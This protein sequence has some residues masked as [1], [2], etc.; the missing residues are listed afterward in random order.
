M[1]KKKLLLTSFIIIT[2]LIICLLIFN[3]YNGKMIIKN[4]SNVKISKVVDNEYIGYVY[5]PKIKLKKN[6]FTFDSPKNN[7]E[8]NVKVLKETIFPQNNKNNSIVFLAAHSGTGDNAYFND[9]K[10]LNINDEIIINYKDTIYKYIIIDKKEV[11]KNGYITGNR[12]NNDEIVL[13]TCS[14]NPKKQLIINGILQKN[15]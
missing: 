11:E 7:I 12:I 2:Y 6:I 8:Y 15:N 3:F 10:L 4:N 13:T 5:I 1:S 9:L 14:E